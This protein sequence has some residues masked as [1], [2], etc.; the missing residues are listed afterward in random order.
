MSKQARRQRAAKQKRRQNYWIGAVAA[1]FVALIALVVVISIRNQRPIGNEQALSTQGNTHIENDT[2]SPIAYN[3]TPP[4]SGPH[5]G[6]I[7][8]WNIY[9]E[10]QRYERVLHNLEDGGVAIYYQCEDGCEE[11][12]DQ[13]EELVTPYLRSDRRIVLVPN[14]PAWRLGNSQPLHQDM[15]NRIALTSWQRIDKFDEFDAERIEAFI[16]RYEGIDHHQ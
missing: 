2:V 1:I 3:S 4:T 10:P 5:Y 13:L 8:P 15:E 9:H 16:E 7:V 12:V 14:D 11:L 6:S